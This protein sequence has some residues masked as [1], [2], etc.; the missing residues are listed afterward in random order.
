MPISSSTISRECATVVVG[1][2]VAINLI[3]GWESVTAEYKFDYH[4]YEI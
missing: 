3:A 2:D 1:E 4:S